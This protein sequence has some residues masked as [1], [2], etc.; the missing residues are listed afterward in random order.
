MPR[1]GEPRSEVPSTAAP[2]PTHPSI[3]PCIP[4]IVTSPFRSEALLHLPEGALGPLADVVLVVRDGDVVEPGLEAEPAQ[5]ARPLR[6]CPRVVVVLLPRQVVHQVAQRQPDLLVVA[7]AV[8]L[9][10]GRGRRLRLCPP[11]ALAA[12]AAASSASAA[13]SSA[14]AADGDT[15]A[16]AVAVGAAEPVLAFMVAAA[17][18]GAGSGLGRG[19]SGGRRGRV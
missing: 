5:L 19:R 4:F 14:A 13:P 11:R 18:T 15:V 8:R 1:P 2:A 7:P 10:R 3:H 12:P 6:R 9:R 17:G 16:V